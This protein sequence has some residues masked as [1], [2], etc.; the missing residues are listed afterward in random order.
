MH[1]HCLKPKH[2]SVL[3][4]TMFLPGSSNHYWTDV[5]PSGLSAHSPHREAEIFI[6]LIN[7]VR[8]AVEVLMMCDGSPAL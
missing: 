6:D 1:F 5:S 2:L 4:F 8:A 7:D 3:G